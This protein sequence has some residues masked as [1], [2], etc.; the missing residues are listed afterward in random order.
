MSCSFRTPF[1]L[2]PLVLLGALAADAQNAAFLQRDTASGDAQAVF[3]RRMHDA[4]ADLQT[5]ARQAEIVGWNLCR[6]DTLADVARTMIAHDVPAAERA[7][8]VDPIVVRDGG[9]RVRFYADAG[10]GQYAPVADVVFAAGAPPTVAFGDS[11][12]PFT[13]AQL[14]LIRAR[15]AVKR[16]H[17]PPCED[18]YSVVA[19][20]AADDSGQV[21]VYQL[22]V[23]PFSARL[24]IGQHMRYTFDAAGTNLVQQRDYARRC[25]LLFTETRDHGEVYSYSATGESLPS[26]IHVFLSLRY[27]KPLFIATLSNN[28]YW[29]VT[30]GVVGVDI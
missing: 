22:R 2:L 28:M 3:A 30:D 18:A 27:G 8:V 7:R 21:W 15:E 12:A 29:H 6:Y 11:L 26:E 10:A 14:G 24:P 25:N 16:D 19:M 4:P 9:W 13:E 5:Q 1:F 23:P 17:V 20:P